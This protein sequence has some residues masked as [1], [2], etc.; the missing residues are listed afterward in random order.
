MWIVLWDSFL[1]KKWLKIRICESVN[2]TWMHRLQLA[3]SN[4]AAEKKKKKTAN[5]AAYNSNPNSYYIFQ[6]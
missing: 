4:N 1:M 6:S 2:S 5:A 3:W